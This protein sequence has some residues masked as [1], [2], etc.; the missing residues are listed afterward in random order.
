MNPFLLRTAV[1]P[2]W[3]RLR[4]QT[5]LQILEDLEDSQWLSSDTIVELQWQKIGELL[6]HAQKNVPYYRGVMQKVGVTVAGIVYSRRL[7][8][9]PILERATITQQRDRLIAENISSDR[10]HPNS[11]GGATGEP[12]QFY[13]DLKGLNQSY[14][15]VWRA[16]RWCG[17]EIGDR[18]AYLWGANFDVSA[19]EGFMGRIRAWALNM[20]ML[21]AWR[22]SKENAL[23][24]LR[25]TVRF[26][27]RLLVC[28]AGSLYQWARLLDFR[29]YTIPGLEAIIVSA[30]T[31]YD[32][33]REAIEH[34]FGVPVYD[35]YGAR[36]FKFVAQECA[37][38]SGLH[39]AAENCYVEIVRE[40]RLAKPGELGEIVITRLDNWA[41]PFIR[42]R[43]GDLGVLSDTLCSCGRGLPLL[44][45]IEGRVQDAIITADGRFVSGLFF[46]HLMKD[47]PEV[48][49]FQVHQ[50]AYDHLVIMLVTQPVGRL[51]SQDRIERIVRDYMGA[52]MRIDFDLR[53][54]IPLTRSGKRRITISHLGNAPVGKDK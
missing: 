15:A 11:T 46:A 45:R 43:T 23:R 1:L 50:I 31:L 10:L 29:N 30:E 21:P 5:S 26:R 44:E 37:E 49:E 35:R 18:Q 47:C 54:Q 6:H 14:A 34:T 22:L 41:M 32:D 40:G 20:L 28:Y 17:V 25:R 33:W 51:P 52:D 24:F 19:Y 27:P 48:R 9:L 38:H 3:Q 42:Y 12:L 16:E 39:I 8:L 4:G 13:D 2:T 36:D 7:D 53:D